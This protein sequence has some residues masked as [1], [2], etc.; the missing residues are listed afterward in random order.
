MGVR[1]CPLSFL[2]TGLVAAVT[3]VAGV[4][5]ATA[6]A[7]GASSPAADPYAAVAYQHDPAHDGDSVD[8]SF[9]APLTKAW[10]TK[11]AGTVGY[12]LIADGRVF[13]TVAHTPNY[14]DDVEALSLATGE[15]LW[16]PKVI[17][18]TYHAGSIAFDDGRVFAINF[19]GLLTAFDAATGAV[20]WAST[21][22]GQWSFTSPPTAIDGTVYVGGA[23]SGGTLYAVDETS[24]TTKWTAQVMNGDDSSPAADADGVYVSYACEQSYRFALD[25]SLAWHHATSCEGGG[26]RT[27]VLHAGK[28]Y[29][30]DAFGMS[31]AV[32]DADT[33]A[34]LGSFA[35][36]PA[37]AFD[38]QHMVTV[39]GAALT[40][41]DPASGEPI[42]QAA[43]NDHVTAPLIANG[44]V[45]EGRSGGTVEARYVQ[46]GTLA[47]SGNIGTGLTAPDEHNATELVG[48]AEG[49]GA[50]AVPAGST[51]T[52]FKPAGNT[53]V[54]ITS[55][56]AD[57]MI[58]GPGRATYTFTSQVAN[59][60]YTCTV[61]GDTT[62]CTS[63]VALTDLDD[64]T[65]H[66]SVA[67]AYA[68][69][70]A[71]ARTL[72][73]D[74]NAPTVGLSPFIPLITHTATI[75]A[76]WTASDRLSGV[77]A[78]QLRIRRARAGTPLP[79]WSV[80]APTTSTSASLRLRPASRL[81]AS[82]RA[83]DTVGNWSGWSTAQCVRRA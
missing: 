28:L 61:D 54:T 21:L 47:W 42:W 79:G 7:A 66:F 67:V 1:R 3:A 48:L 60:Q 71:A 41:S 77:R 4:C 8:P 11:L 83:E 27:A 29:V 52:I 50:L 55:G 51:L 56:P 65:H 75:T 30:R 81:C 12:P 10:T 25:G 36:G 13:V 40:V 20:D 69:S 18:G 15:V 33:G 39:S 24:G 59:A 78:Y 70:G 80:R 74:A 58:V 43:G 46:D 63:P 35:A 53:D 72:R 22:G 31:P 37:P 57:G 26:G 68:T 44:Y 32:L 19:D 5:V 23:G 82:V 6:P 64:G 14:G 9:V 38:E 34:Q 17:G 62:P 73:V 49:D 45:I 76:R 16:G 2:T